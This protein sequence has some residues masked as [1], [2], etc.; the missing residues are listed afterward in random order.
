MRAEAR[1]PLADDAGGVAGLLEQRGH[2][3][4]ARLDDQRGDAGQDAGALLA[5]GVL[6]G[7][8]GVARGRAD[9]RRASARR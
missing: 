5:P 4:A 2:G 6:A 9:G 8:E 7:H 1:V 3:H